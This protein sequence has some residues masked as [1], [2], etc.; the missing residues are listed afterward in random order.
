VEA[1]HSGG[2]RDRQAL[3]IMTVVDFGKGLVIDH[4]LAPQSGWSAVRAARM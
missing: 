1:Q 2:L 3:A 4:D